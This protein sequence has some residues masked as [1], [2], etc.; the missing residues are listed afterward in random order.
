MNVKVILIRAAPI[1]TAKIPTVP[2]PVN[3]TQDI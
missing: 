2:T 1:L 3:V